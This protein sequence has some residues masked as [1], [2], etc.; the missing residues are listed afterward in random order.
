MR[1][2]GA[3]PLRDPGRG[4]GD[5]RQS[6]GDGHDTRDDARWTERDRDPRD[7]F[8]R[9]LNL[10]RREGF[11][12]LRLVRTMP[13]LVGVPIGVLTSSNAV[14]DRSRT[15]RIGADRYIYKPPVLEQFIEEVG[16]AVAELLSL[17]SRQ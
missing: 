4:P 16:K 17:E 1:Y 15:A 10:P 9:D 3:S 6:N 13:R 14:R 5:S 11:D 2:A 12:V 8:T 7:V